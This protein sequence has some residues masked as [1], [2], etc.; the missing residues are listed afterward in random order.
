M[1]LIKEGGIFIWPLFAVSISGAAIIAERLHVFHQVTRK[2][3]IEYE[4]PTQIL[5][6]LRTRLTGLQTI[7]TI[8]PMLGLLGTVTGLMRCFSLLGDQ[9]G[10]Y[11]PQEISLGISE[12]LI[13]TAVGL[14]IAVV[15]TIFYNFF[16]ARLETYLQVYNDALEQGAHDD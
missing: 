10:G 14:I 3:L 11:R 1:Q 9:G 13:T 15:A 12:A 8:A 5:I 7:I 16:V 2:P 4:F 6:Q